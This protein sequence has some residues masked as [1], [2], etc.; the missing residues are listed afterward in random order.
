MN[1][2]WYPWGLTVNG[3]SPALAI[4][5]WQHI[6]NIFKQQGASNVKFL[7]CPNVRGPVWDDGNA[8]SSFYPGDAY[9]DSIGLDGYN[10]GPPT[11]PWYSFTQVFQPTYNEIRNTVSSTKP[12]MVVEVGSNPGSTSTQ[13]AAWIT[14][15]ENDLPS[16]FPMI[17]AL[18]YYDSNVSGNWRYDSNSIDLSAFT[19]LAADPRW[20]GGRPLQ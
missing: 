18:S 1:G 20:Q 9:V 14:Q 12:I 17:K 4:Q 15:M 8:L 7:W 19:A 16:L 11:L 5:A 6:Y 13:R 3:N 2:N 10:L